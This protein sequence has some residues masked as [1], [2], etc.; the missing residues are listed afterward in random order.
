MTG[1]PVQE[2]G[3]QV[4]AEVRQRVYSQGLP[5][6]VEEHGIRVAVRGDHGGERVEVHRNQEEAAR[7]QEPGRVRPA[8][9]PAVERRLC[10]RGRF[11]DRW[12]DVSDEARTDC[13]CCCP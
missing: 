13:G 4:V 3:P 6:S 7:R 11:W 2:E 5:R 8:E 9:E 1:A 12:V 10:A